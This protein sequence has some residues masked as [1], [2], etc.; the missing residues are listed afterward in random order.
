MTSRPQC[1]PSTGNGSEPKQPPANPTPSGGVEGG[2]RSLAPP[3]QYPLEELLQ[4]VLQQEKVL[5]RRNE[6]LL[7]SLR[8]GEFYCQESRGE[9]VDR[10]LGMR[11]SGLGRWVL[12]AAC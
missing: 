3:T 7:Q 6:A 12:S 2:E 10:L 9:R 4:E 8:V 11:W 1:A 5:W